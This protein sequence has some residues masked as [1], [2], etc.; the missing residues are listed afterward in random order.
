VTQAASTLG[1]KD[2]NCII[3]HPVTTKV[4]PIKAL[5]G[6]R[7]VTK[8]AKKMSKKRITDEDDVLDL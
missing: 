3:C 6:W 7:K 2:I 4:V 5:R 8:A 1:E